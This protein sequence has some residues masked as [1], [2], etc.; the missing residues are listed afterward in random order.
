MRLPPPTEDVRL[1]DGEH[2]LSV[3]G[4]LEQLCAARAELSAQL[5]TQ[6]MYALSKR[7]A[8][9]Q[10]RIRSVLEGMIGATPSATVAI[11][12]A[13]PSNAAMQGRHAG[14]AEP[15]EAETETVWF[16]RWMRSL[17]DE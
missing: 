12:P 13:W 8:I 16:E 15:S 4:A 14:G 11:M 6:D 3:R 5:T 2:G 7:S 1:D 9:N 17:S 10:A